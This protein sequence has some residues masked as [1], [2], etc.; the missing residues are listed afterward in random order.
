[1]KLTDAQLA[2]LE[3]EHAAAMITT[4]DD[5]VPKVARVAVALVDGKLWSS[6]TDSRVRT[7]R[8]R[9]D[10]RCT[11]FVFDATYK[12]L[13]LETN[14]RILE[15]ADVPAQSVRLFRTMQ[16][17]PTGKLSWFGQEMSEEEMLQAMSAE[18]RVIY[19]FDITHAYGMV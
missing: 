5:G 11:V 9:R 19:E 2:F 13:T 12:W 6:G 15:S 3:H 4:G 8:L 16:N 7:A 14:V 17:R 1:M 18:K 10:A